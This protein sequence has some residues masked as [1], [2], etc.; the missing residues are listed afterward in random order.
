M[1]AIDLLD[2]TGADNREIGAELEAA[3]FKVHHVKNAREL[4]HTR[5]EDVMPILAF[6]LGSIN[7]QVLDLTHHAK[8][9]QL[10]RLVVCGT[11]RHREPKRLRLLESGA[12]EVVPLNQVPK[13]IRDLVPL[14]T[15]GRSTTAQSQRT[16]QTETTTKA[17]AL[18]EKSGQ[19]F[20]QL[21][22]GELSNALQFLCMSPRTGKLEISFEGD[23]EKALI[24]LAGQTVV[25][26]TAHEKE[27]VQAMA[28]IMQQPGQREVAFYEGEEAPAQTNDKPLSQF[29]L[30]ASVMADDE[31]STT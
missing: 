13:A 6:L 22:Q 20:L 17:Q 2:Q 12:D 25:H 7:N 28:N 4:K 10:G 1:N 30:Q 29:L 11:S 26:V 18:Q 31:S 21:A 9:N 24:F 14:Y 3:G 16:A 27:G 19:M 15:P 8:S 23:S 5:Q